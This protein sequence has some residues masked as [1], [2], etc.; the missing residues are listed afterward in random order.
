[1]VDGSDGG[2]VALLLRGDHELNPLK[3]ARVPGIARPLQLAAPDRVARELGAPTGFIG[4]V[5]LP[6]RLIADHSALALADFIC[7]ANEADAHRSGVNWERDLP[8]AEAADLRNVENGDRS[9][10]GGGALAIA[11]GIE[12]GHIF[13]LGDKY[14]RAM[15]AVVLDEAGKERVMTM[16]CYGIG[17]SRILGAAIEQN[18]DDNGIIWPEPMSPFHA[19]L[20]ELNPKQSEA[21]TVAARSIYEALQKAGFDV[22]YDDRD[23]RPGVKFADA[24]LLGIPHRFVVGERGVKDGKAE[25][26]HRRSGHQ[27][28]V[29]IAAV[30]EY[31]RGQA[32]G[33]P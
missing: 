14:S 10:G 5:G 6:C 8:V 26:R 28:N 12:V 3:A 33:G 32:A 4:P 24:D 27:D 20:V 23:A 30:A 2:L 1:V 25:Y 29:A 13:Q 31:L 7:G 21:V 17:V 22:L 16:G 15:K 9:P 19:V 18:H 11:R